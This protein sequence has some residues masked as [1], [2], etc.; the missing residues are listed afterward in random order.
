M[1]IIG[2]TF[3]KVDILTSED[4]LCHSILQDLIDIA[5]VPSRHFCL[6]SY[7]KVSNVLIFTGLI[8]VCCPGKHS[9]WEFM[10]AQWRECVVFQPDSLYHI[11][12]LFPVY[13]GPWFWDE[14]LVS[15]THL[16]LSP[17]LCPSFSALTP[18]MNVC[19]SPYTQNMWASVIKAQRIYWV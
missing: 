19:I 2:H 10:C 3:T 4:D 13:D 17:L 18:L 5:K 15:L 1:L 8:C 7:F 6:L 14:R 11:C 9:Y 16:W 12:F